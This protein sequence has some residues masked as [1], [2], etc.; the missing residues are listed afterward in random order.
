M[1]ERDCKLNRGDIL[2]LIKLKVMINS[3]VGRG[4]VVGGVFCFMFM[5]GVN[6]RE[7]L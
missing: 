7:G 2:L 3:A 6:G 1:V 4:G 5:D